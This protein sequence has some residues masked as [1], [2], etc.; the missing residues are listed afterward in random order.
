MP[1]IMIVC[2][3]EIFDLSGRVVQ[4]PSDIWRPHSSATISG[5]IDCAYVVEYQLSI[6]KIPA[7]IHFMLLLQ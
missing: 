6:V 1:D 7:I 4:I 5:V 2:P 3:S